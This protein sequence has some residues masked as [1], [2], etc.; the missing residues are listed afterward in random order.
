MVCN[1]ARRE[2]AKVI[3]RRSGMHKRAI[4]KP[5][6]LARSQMEE[7]GGGWGREKKGKIE[8]LR[9][10]GEVGTRRSAEEEEELVF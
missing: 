3:N 10:G 9:K 5:R 2:D 1:L 6:G 8:D 4:N 7:R